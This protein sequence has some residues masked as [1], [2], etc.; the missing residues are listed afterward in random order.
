MESELEDELTKVTGVSSL[1]QAHDPSSASPMLT[2]WSERFN[3]RHS[4]GPTAMALW[5]VVVE[6]HGKETPRLLIGPS[7]SRS[8]VP[9][10]LS[11]Q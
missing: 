6:Q 3:V 7:I 8:L 1:C 5:S 9:I 2:P 11:T 10:V 4:Q